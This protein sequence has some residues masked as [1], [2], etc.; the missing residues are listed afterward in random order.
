[1]SIKF[2]L[3]IVTGLL[4]AMFFN[5]NFIMADVDEKKSESMVANL[6]QLVEPI[7]L[8][9]TYSFAGEKM[10]DNFDTY[11]RLD[12]EMLVNAYWQSSTLLNIKSANR[13][14]SGY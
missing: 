1:M 13:Y 11:E 4:L 5:Y 12:R 14:F 2:V 10:P 7:D 3:G 6:P 9:K 8:D